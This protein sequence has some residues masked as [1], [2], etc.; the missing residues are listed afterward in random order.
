M[1]E[2][3]AAPDQGVTGVPQDPR[4]AFLG[5]PL[6]NHSIEEFLAENNQPGH[7]QG[8]GPALHTCVLSAPPPLEGV[9]RAR[10]LARRLHPRPPKE[11]RR[12]KA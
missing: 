11:D 5:K 7:L 8:A 1:E 4:I 10:G 9:E 2:K 6:G 3:F 12:T